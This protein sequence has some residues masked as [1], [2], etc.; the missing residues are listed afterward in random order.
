[1]LCA[2]KHIGIFPRGVSRHWQILLPVIT[3][4]VST[5]ADSFA[6]DNARGERDALSVVSDSL[7]PAHQSR[8]SDKVRYQKH[9]QSALVASEQLTSLAT[10]QPCPAA[11]SASAPRQASN[12][13]DRPGT[14]QS[15]KRM[16]V[17]TMGCLPTRSQGPPSNQVP[18]KY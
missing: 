15:S 2:V 11:A 18:L 7:H 6:G 14:R 1:M 9:E 13:P 8:R 3:C 17:G 5:L 12:D 16:H 10:S 4:G